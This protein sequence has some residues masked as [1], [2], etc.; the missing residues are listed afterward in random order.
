MY[1]VCYKAKNEFHFFS[2]S[3]ARSTLKKLTKLICI[4]YAYFNACFLNH[5]GDQTSNNYVSSDATS[6]I[7]I[8]ST[9]SLFIGKVEAPMKGSY[10]CEASNGFGKPLTKTIQISVR[11]KF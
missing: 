2:L 1:F 4:F 11:G 6:I 7:K 3:Y 9:G 5:T 8:S 10:T